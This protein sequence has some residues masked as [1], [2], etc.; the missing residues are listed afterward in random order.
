MNAPSLPPLADV[1]SAAPLPAPRSRKPGRGRVLLGLLLPLAL[2]LGWEFA[3]RSGL[4]QG[5]LMPP[6]SRI[7]NALAALARSGELWSHV[8]TTSMRVLAGFALGAI[9]GTLMGALAG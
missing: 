3:V 1:S 4:A 5:R 2:A 7:Y 9:A 8:S 6:P